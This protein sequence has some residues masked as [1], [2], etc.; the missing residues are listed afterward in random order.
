MGLTTH[1]HVVLKLI[2]TG[3]MPPLPMEW[4]H[5]Q[6][7][8][9]LFPLNVHNASSYCISRKKLTQGRLHVYITDTIQNYAPHLKNFT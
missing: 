6:R 2:M 1:L 7:Q 3:T 4:R 9:Y 8:L 5:I